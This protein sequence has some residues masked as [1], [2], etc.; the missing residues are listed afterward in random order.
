[1]HGLLVTMLI[2]LPV[3]M[4]FIVRKILLCVDESIEGCETLPI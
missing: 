4:S 1:M 2:E 3:Q